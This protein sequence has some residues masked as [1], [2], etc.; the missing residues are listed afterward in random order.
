MAQNSILPRFFIGQRVKA[1]A[2]TNCFGKQVE[3]T[4]GLTVT[5]YKLIAESS[6]P[7]YYRITAEGPHMFFEA[8][9]RFFALDEV[10]EPETIGECWEVRQ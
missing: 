9:E 8:A 1:I 2:F 4:K 6:I 3:E 10:P 5:S 7:A